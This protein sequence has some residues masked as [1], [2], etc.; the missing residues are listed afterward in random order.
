MDIKNE[1]ELIEWVYDMHLQNLSGRED[2]LEA[3]KQGIESTIEELKELKFLNLDFVVG[4]SEATEQ[5]KAEQ[6][7]FNIG[8]NGGTQESANDIQI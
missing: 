2:F 4:G 7:P 5:L 3:F 6:K 1:K 8:V